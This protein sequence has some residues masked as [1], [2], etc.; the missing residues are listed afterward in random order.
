M[1]PADYIRLA[2]AELLENVGHNCTLAAKLTSHLVP[3]LKR[4]QTAV[5]QLQKP[6]WWIHA[7]GK[8]AE[9]VMRIVDL[10]RVQVGN[11]FECDV[12]IVGAG[13]AGITLASELANTPLQVLVVESGGD[14]SENDFA[15]G[16]NEIVSVGAPRVMK[17]QLVRNRVVGGSSF[18]WFGRCTSLD[19]MDYEAR[20]WMPYSGWPISALDLQPYAARSAAYLGLGSA[21][22]SDGLPQSSGLASHLAPEQTPSLRVIMYQFSSRSVISTD[23]VRFG[24]RFRSLQASN[25][26]LI[27]HATVTQIEISED[28]RRVTGLEIR[29]PQNA[30]HHVHAGTVVLCGG[31][32]ENARM[33]LTSTRSDARGVGNKHGMVGRFFMDHPRTTVG[34]FTTESAPKIQQELGLFRAAS[35]ARVQC[36]LSLSFDLQRREGLLNC[37]AWTTQHVAEDDAWRSL[38][39]VGLGHGEQR[40]EALK[41]F[42]RNIDQVFVGL[43]QKLVIGKGL[44]RRL[45][46]LDLD[47]MVE[48]L[49]DPESR[50]R[51]SS[52]CD[53]LGVPLS[54]IDWKISELE[55]RSVIRLAREVNKAMAAAGLPQATLK[56]WVQQ[57]R[58]EDATFCDPAHPLGATRMAD[59]PE[60][61]VVDRDGRVFGIDNLY[62]AG[63]STFPTGGHANPTF[64]IVALAL[65]LADHLRAL[66][67]E[68]LT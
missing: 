32:I 52:R 22:Y 44:V 12:C 20:S 54:V 27:T 36:G 18:S 51:L 41:V 26:R 7:I 13:P 50:V 11:S 17:Q 25:V 8:G 48:Q 47:V 67:A 34:T 53:A 4:V 3:E 19:A 2:P 6:S 10:R 55:G 24:A 35:G 5:T 9:N 23:Y 40:L 1:S 28:R 39:K 56:D 57:D 59:R 63:S 66:Q 64:T 37:A 14:S 31:G 65:R 29:S 33:L 58:P 68:W 60:N 43:W 46:Q 21:L 38:R 15:A 45:K 49:P 62:I 30:C 16:L 61:G 42:S